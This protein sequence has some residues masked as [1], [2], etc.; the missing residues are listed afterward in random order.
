MH[1]SS[2][3][4]RLRSPVVAIVLSLT[5]AATRNV[6]AQGRD[7]VKTPTGAFIGRIISSLDSAPAR[8]VDIRLLYVDSTRT[9]KARGGDS[10]DVFLDST[11]TR[12][13]ASDSIGRFAIRRLAAGHYLFR[14]RR[15]GYQ[16]MDGVLNIGDDTVQV[17]FI[18][19]VA[20]TMLAKM[21]ITESSV[22]RVKE[23][24]Y[25]NGYIAR[26]HLG[27]AA[28][29]IDRPEILRRRTQ[30]MSEMLNAYGVADGDFV[31]DRMSLTYE[32][33][34]DYPT[35]L[36]IGIEIYRHNRPVEFNMMRSSS[37]SVLTAGGGRS[38]PLVL[39]WTYIPGR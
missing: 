6:S 9:I 21:Q 38:A 18:M 23:Q 36:V 10:I 24:L 29:F 5:L 25:T 8:S 11:R 39:I 30:T 33:I 27:I 14:L 28:T 13:A 22:D 35:E 17:K 1:L 19:Q 2:R 4:L 16:P 7:S 34:R 12:V 15:I 32:D 31:L 26:T 3:V 37:A 20:S